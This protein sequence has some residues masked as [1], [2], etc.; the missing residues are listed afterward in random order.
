MNKV[1]ITGV[2]IVSP[3]GNTVQEYWNSL[4]EG[5]CG[6]DYIKRFDTEDLDVKI[7]AEVKDL[8]KELYLSRS[9]IKCSDLF[10]QYGVCAAMQAF[11]DSGI[12]KNID[13][14]R[15]GV[16]F[17][18]GI[19]GISSLETG[20]ETYQKE[21][22]HAISPYYIS[23]SIVNS[24]A[25]LIAIKCHAK[26]SCLSVVTACASSSHSIGEAYRTI[27]HGYADAI[28]AGGSDAGITPTMISGFANCG[29]LSLKK[30]PEQASIP[31]DRRRDGFVMGEGAGALILEEYE[32]AKKRKAKIYAEIVGYGTT[33]DAYHITASSQDSESCSKAIRLAME[34]VSN[35]PL[36]HLYINAHGTST[37]KNDKNET[38]AIKKVF[39]EK[40]YDISIS[41]TKS[42]MGHMMGAAGAAEAIATVLSLNHSF[43]PPT[44]GLNEPDED[45]DL[46]YTPNKGVKR[47]I[48]LGM[49]LSMG[50]GGHNA[51]LL[52]R[53]ID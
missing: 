32:H 19:G 1:V 20:F 30:H 2:G 39:G 50:F 53:K 27:K 48:E 41:S 25:G 21:S 22:A 13:E 16:Y 40:S 14:Q 8:E 45:C 18:S 38:F 49:S 28:I 34:G 31:F 47:F 6:I 52:F 17:G 33:C 26:G 3:I 15:L 46:N 35:I 23:K 4:K 12:D 10:A 5:K 9:E 24:T 37:P 11:W 36:N 51:C 7:D 29:A 42:M 44:I 43:I